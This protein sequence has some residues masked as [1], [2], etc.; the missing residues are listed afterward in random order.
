MEAIQYR[1]QDFEGP[2]D[3]LLHLVDINKIDIYDIPIA[4]ITD[5]YM[6]W[7][8]DA[9]LA[10][11]DTASSFLRMAAQLLYIKSQMLL[12]APPAPEEEQEDPRAALTRLLLEY[13]MYR[14]LGGR[15]KQQA[16]QAARYFFKEET[17]PA[18]LDLEPEP[19]DLQELTGD[20]TLS[21][22]KRIFQDVMK[23]SFDRVD[24]RRSS[25]GRIEAEPVSFSRKSA[26][27]RAYIRKKK[28][29]ISFRR[30]LE[31]SSSRDE[32]IVA[33]LVILEMM[34]DGTVSTRQDSLFDDIYIEVA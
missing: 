26:Q 27:I 22:L 17:L 12:P 24:A 16:A 34:K 14:Y 32:V 8:G 25:F 3:L 33:F 13:K 28:K 20:T 30:M 10:D 7:I 29:G 21:D 19:V 5:Q 31:D 11:M 18:D 23:R 6:A 4:E 15:L 2:L 9:S 1:L